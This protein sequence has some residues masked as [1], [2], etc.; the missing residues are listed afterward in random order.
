MRKPAFY[1]CQKQT[2]KLASLTGHADQNLSFRREVSSFKYFSVTVQ[3]GF[4]FETLVTSFFH[5]RAQM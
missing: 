5:D 1:I 3:P 2:S 4:C